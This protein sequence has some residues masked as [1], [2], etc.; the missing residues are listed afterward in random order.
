MKS[1]TAF[2]VAL[3]IFIAMAAF[4]VLS[5]LGMAIMDACRAV[6]RKVRL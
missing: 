4:T 1:L 3:V 5:M 6:D 2:Q